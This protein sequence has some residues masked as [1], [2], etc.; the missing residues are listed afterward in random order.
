MM[1][2]IPRVSIGLAV[3]NGEKY[4]SQTLDSIVD[5][6]FGDF[7]LVISDNASSD[8]TEDICR[9]Y[10]ARD[11]R[12]RYSQSPVNIGLTNNFNRAFRLSSGQ[13]FRWAAADDVFAP[14][15]LERCVDI[16]DKH[17]EVV[18]CYPKTI[19]IDDNGDPLRDYDDNLDLRL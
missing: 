10:A 11:A 13:Y 1:G 8:G 14:T 3:Y 7:E 18:L 19:L 4:L 2:R 17:S 15:S 9:Q 12:I 6:T 16:L 5:Q